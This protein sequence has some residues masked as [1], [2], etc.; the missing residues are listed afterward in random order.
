MWERVHVVV[1]FFKSLYIIYIFFFTYFR[2]GPKRYIS[3]EERERRRVKQAEYRAR[4]ME[5][6]EFRAAEVIRTGVSENINWICNFSKKILKCI[7]QVC[8]Q[9]N[10]KK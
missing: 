2:M 6:P 5:K 4:M 3:P 10:E 7:C 8:K 9:I 1:I